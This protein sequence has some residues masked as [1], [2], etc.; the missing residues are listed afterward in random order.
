MVTAEME[1]ALAAKLRM[2]SSDTTPRRLPKYTTLD[3]PGVLQAGEESML[4][5]FALVSRREMKWLAASDTVGAIASQRSQHDS[6]ACGL[7]TA[8][9][10]LRAPTPALR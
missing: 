1:P 5:H 9:C 8:R 7:P 4:H 6:W 10:L 3:S 2:A